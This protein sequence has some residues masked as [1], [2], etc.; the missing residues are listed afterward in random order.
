MKPR[1]LLDRGARG[2]VRNVKFADLQRLVEAMGFEP[3]RTRGSH[4]MYRHPGVREKVNIQPQ[5][6]QAKPYQVRQVV[7]LAA[8]YSLEV[9]NDQ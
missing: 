8:R 6:H 1:A 4:I 7:E 2:D 3:D 5:G 9:E